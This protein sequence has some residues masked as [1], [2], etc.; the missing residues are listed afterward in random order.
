V[1][2]VHYIPRGSPLWDVWVPRFWCDHMAW[3]SQD[4]VADA[5]LNHDWVWNKY[6]DAPVLEE[7]QVTDVPARVT[8]LACLVNMTL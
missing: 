5:R 1:R 3:L 7:G 8:C 4:K 2:L 6:K